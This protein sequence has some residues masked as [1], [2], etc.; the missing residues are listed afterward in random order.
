MSILAYLQ[1]GTAL[2]V[3]PIRRQQTDY[4]A[5]LI[6]DADTIILKPL[7]LA[8]ELLLASDSPIAVASDLA[9]NDVLNGHINAGK[10]KYSHTIL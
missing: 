4:D 9:W 1:A 3:S 7:D 10:L 8:F 5:V 6:L 2:M